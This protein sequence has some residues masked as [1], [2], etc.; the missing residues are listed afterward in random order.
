MRAPGRPLEV[1]AQTWFTDKRSK[2]NSED[3]LTIS[4]TESVDRVSI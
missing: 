3:Y 1:T 2:L 4:L